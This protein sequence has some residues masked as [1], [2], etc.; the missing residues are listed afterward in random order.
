MK[1]IN[2]KDNL[3]YYI[4]GVVRDMLLDRESFDIDITFVGN[5]IEYCKKFGKV[6]RENPDFG[7]IRIDIDGEEID[8]ASTRTETYPKKGHLP[9]VTKIGCSL[10]EDVLRRDFSINALAMNCATEEIIDYVNGQE[11]LKN[12]VIRV[13]HDESFIDDPS[14]IIRGLKFRVRFGF[15][16]EKHTRELQENYLANI[17]YDMSYKRIKKEL[18]ETF[19]LNSQKAFEIFVNEKIYKLV[20]PADFV[21]PKIN[22][23][24]LVNK[25]KSEINPDLIWL[26]YVGLLPDLT[27]LELTK[28][29][30]KIIEDYK[31]DENPQTDFEIYKFFENK[32]IISVLLYGICNNIN[33]A[34]RYLNDLRKIKISTTGNDLKNLGINPSLKYAEIFDEILREKLKNPNMIKEDELKT[35]K[36]FMV[37]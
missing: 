28:Q 8:F 5:A 33:A 1:I 24:S 27:N 18:A 23:E 17:N 6:I 26:V 10:K 22:I 2:V 30:R 13:L 15:D 25:Y 9:I 31:S 20:S 7:T 16:L 4:G 32:N 34:E 19:N 29:E 3:L 36:K 21:L 37:Q 14:R 12:R 35:A 11:D